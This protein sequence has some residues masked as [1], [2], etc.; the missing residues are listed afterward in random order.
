[1]RD[2]SVKWHTV[3]PRQ[4]LWDFSKTDPQIDRVLA[5]KLNPLMLLPFPSAPWCS[6]ADRKKIRDQSRDARYLET[7]YVVA[8]PAKDP[9]LFRNYVAR[10]VERYR[11]RIVYYE[12][13]NE[14][15]YTSYAVPQ[16]FGY[17][18]QDYLKI[19]RDAY[20][21]IKANQPNA[22]VI[23][24]IGA[25]VDRHWVNEFVDAGGL[26]WCDAMDIHLYPVTIPPEIYGKDLAKCWKKMRDRGQ[27][28]PIWLTEIGCYADDDPY[29]TPNVIGDAAMSRANWPSEREAAEAMVKTAAVFLGHGVA[30]IFYHAGTCGPINGNDG[31]GV[32]FE[33]GA[34]PRKMYVALSA[35]A[36]RLGPA[37]KP[38]PPI[39]AADP[40]QAYLF[41][42]EEGAVAIAWWSGDRSPSLRLGDRVT[43][44]DI[45]GN[46]IDQTAV[47][48]GDTPLY[49]TGPNADS[50]R[51]TLS[52]FAR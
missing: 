47:V 2:W 8:C 10:T 28:K 27:A 29:K 44:T 22:Q 34:A 49:L 7:R 50:L 43:A 35:L 14:P 31:G 6:A 41:E 37:P 12:I 24:G 21:T 25:W 4:G 1:M 11:N 30:K 5:A 3:E 40:L 36:N 45:M 13:M 33:Y 23:G 32:F 42:T 18:L 26:Q 38:L 15:L 9:A 51:K 52:Q 17:G 46:P 19:L 39:S 20:E 48:L 16:Q